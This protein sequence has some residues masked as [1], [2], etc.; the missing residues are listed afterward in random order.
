MYLIK[1]QSDA[2]LVFKEYKKQVELEFG[3]RFKCLRTN[4]SGEYT[5]DEFLA[6]CK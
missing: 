4:N 3:I 5:D 2:V 1:K 6:Y